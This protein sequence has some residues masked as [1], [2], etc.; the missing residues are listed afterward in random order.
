MTERKQY[1]VLIVDDTRTNLRILME[2]LKDHYKV[3]SA[4]SGAKALE[5]LNKGPIP[6]LI[7]LD[8][9]MPE[10]SGFQVMQK[11]RKRAALCEIPVIFVTA[12]AETKDET[13]GL[14]FGAVDYIT[15]PIE[16]SVVLARVRTQIKLLE[17][18]RQ[19]D[20]I[21]GDTL[22]GMTSLLTDLLSYA[23]PLVYNRTLRLRM[24]IDKIVKKLEIPQNWE[25]ELAAMLSQLDNINLDSDIINKLYSGQVKHHH[26]YPALS[27]NLLGNIPNLGNLSQI[28]VEQDKSLADLITEGMD[29]VEKVED[30]KQW[31]QSS[32]G[33]ALLKIAN[34]V[35]EAETELGDIN[36]SY[37]Q[38]ALTV[39]PICAPLADCLTSLAQDKRIKEGLS[40]DKLVIGMVLEE[41][42][43][44]IQESLILPAGSP[45]TSENI[46][47]IEL[48]RRGIGVQE[49]V[50]VSYEESM[51]ED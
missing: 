39:A 7:L 35:E 5:M 42:L 32:L 8:I 37:Q 23:N 15:K 26:D 2:I 47:R 3:F 20:S 9:M 45:L 25:F 44:T 29:N 22:T 31:D 17:A 10:M 33:A 11:L 48:F 4:T 21:Y 41:D 18:R 28:L 40:V 30:L 1:R 19:I 38:V 43:F 34:M 16:P 12:M 51:L 13:K 36:A 24:H 14:S 49:R 46:E 50:L 6:D 27:K